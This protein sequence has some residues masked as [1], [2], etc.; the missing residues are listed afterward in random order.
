MSGA[1]TWRGRGQAGFT[2]LEIMVALVVFGFL[3]AGLIQGVQ[4]G[5][6]AWNGQTALIA[7]RGDLDAVDTTLRGLIESMDPG[8][9]TEAPNIVGLPHAVAFTTTLPAGAADADDRHADISL[10]VD[11]NHDLILRFTPHLHAVR[12][13]AAPRIHSH[14]LLGGVAQVNFGYWRQNGGWTTRWNQ[15]TPPA[16]LRIDIMLADNRNWPAIIVA[17]MRRPD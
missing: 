5:L 4:F 6:R 14:V 16:L 3:L 17:P 7:Q 15:S 10:S 12:L 9:A 8:S 1:I 2:L 13:G 11:D